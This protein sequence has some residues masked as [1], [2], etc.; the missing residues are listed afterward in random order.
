MTAVT[1]HEV[2]VPSVLPVNSEEELTKNAPN[3]SA[4]EIS[5]DIMMEEAEVRVDVDCTR[6]V[7]SAVVKK[8]STHKGDTLALIYDTDSFLIVRPLSAKPKSPGK[9]HESQRMMLANCLTTVKNGFLGLVYF[10]M[11]LELLALIIPVPRLIERIFPE[12]EEVERSSLVAPAGTMAPTGKEEKTEK[13]V[14]EA[15][16][17]ETEAASSVWA[18]L[19]DEFIQVHS[20]LSDRISALSL[21]IISEP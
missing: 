18:I 1:P 9:G 14:D 15:P 6:P 12:E 13:K 7:E 16:K 21:L 11:A 5:H 4:I 20:R 8:E 17:K 2:A 19:L 10:L 3:D